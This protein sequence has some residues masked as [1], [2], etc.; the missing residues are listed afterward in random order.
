MHQVLTLSFAIGLRGGIFIIF[1]L[2]KQ[3]TI[4]DPNI[5]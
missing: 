1:T 4:S 2:I 3:I 5:Q